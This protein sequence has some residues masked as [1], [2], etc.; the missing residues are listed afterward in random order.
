M[1]HAQ[2]KTQLQKQLPQEQQLKKLKTRGKFLQDDDRQTTRGEA[3]HQ[4]SDTKGRK[5]QKASS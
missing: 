1:K 2:Y 5:T 4:E 3:G